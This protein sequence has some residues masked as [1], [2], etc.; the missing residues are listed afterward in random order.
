VAINS[1]SPSVKVDGPRNRICVSSLIGW[2][3]SL[4]YS[5]R[6][7]IPGKC[8]SS[9]MKGILLFLKKKKGASKE[10]QRL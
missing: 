4:L 6:P 10:L 9:C 8:S 5:S 7:V 2:A 1:L 3:V